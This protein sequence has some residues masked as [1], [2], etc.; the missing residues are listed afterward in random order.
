M[1]AASLQI[2][3]C[4]NVHAG[5]ITEAHIHLCLYHAYVDKDYL[6]NPSSCSAKRYTG[7]N[8]VHVVDYGASNE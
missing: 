8:Y 7:R 1:M 3:I 5:S 6:A 2:H 4:I